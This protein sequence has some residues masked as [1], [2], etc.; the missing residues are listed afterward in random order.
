MIPRINHAVI[1]F[2]LCLYQLP[3]I[4]CSLYIIVRAT[5]CMGTT[6]MPRARGSNADS[7][8]CFHV[9]AIGGRWLRRLFRRIAVAVDL[10]YLFIYLSVTWSIIDLQQRTAL[11]WRCYM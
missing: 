10:I 8:H 5:C 4:V 2:I 9:F 1:V 7:E 3:V 11:K 6:H